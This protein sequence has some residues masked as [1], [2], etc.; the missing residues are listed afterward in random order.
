MDAS[1]TS[2]SLEIKEIRASD[3][4]VMTKPIVLAAGQNLPV[5]AVIGKITDDE[6]ADFG[7][8]VL[9]LADATDGSQKPWG[10]L[11]YAVNATAAAK[12]ATAYVAGDF[13]GKN[14]TYGTGHTAES[15]FDDLRAGGVYVV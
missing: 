8:C 15:V 14:L 3:H 9:S 2:Q 4:P 6:S 5:G 12:K 1:F 7:K 11:T 13:V 10:V